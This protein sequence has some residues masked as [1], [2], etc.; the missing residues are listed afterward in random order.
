VNRVAISRSDDTR[1]GIG[2]IVGAVLLMTLADALVKLASANFSLWQLYV[3][4]GLFALPIL[5]G[6]MRWRGMALWPVAPG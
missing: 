1:L 6:I 2:L 3:T 5:I 4:R